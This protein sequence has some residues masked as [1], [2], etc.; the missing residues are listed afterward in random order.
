MVVA[1]TKTGLML[2]PSF[3]ELQR[4]N[5]AEILAATRQNG[6][7]SLLHAAAVVLRR[8]QN[9]RLRAAGMLSAM[10]DGSN[11]RKTIEQVPSH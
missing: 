4:A 9:E 3:I 1:L 11:D 2:V 6:V 7:Q 8:K 5:G 10:G